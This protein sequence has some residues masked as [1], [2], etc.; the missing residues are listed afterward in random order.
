MARTEASAARSASLATTAS[1]SSTS[2]LS[3]TGLEI[4]AVTPTLPSS[5]ITKP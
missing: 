3:K 1:P 2:V 4:T 5:R